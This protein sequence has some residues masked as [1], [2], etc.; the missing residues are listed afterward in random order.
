MLYP[1]PYFCCGCSV[2]V[3]LKAILF[4]HGLYCL[5][6]IVEAFVSLVLQGS[7]YMSTWSYETQLLNAMWAMVGLP[8][9]GMALYGLEK[10]LEASVRL[11]LYYLF[12]CFVL[13]TVQ[14]FYTLVF[15]NQCTDST[16]SDDIIYLFLGESSHA[17]GCGLSRLVGYL[18][19]S[20]I[21]TVEV[22]CLWLVWSF[23]AEV[24][25]GKTSVKV[26]DLLKGLPTS[27]F[28]KNPRQDG[29]YADIVGLAHT[30]LPGAYPFNYGALGSYDHDVARYLESD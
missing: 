28:K 5:F 22:Y 18:L 12:A 23:C 13:N 10:R 4:F 30:R 7:M 6:F 29:P 27:M 21:V 11:Y 24:A 17:F 25:D 3:G 8:L 2:A 19:V 15:M 1:L 9:I 16:S 14:A 20:A 26:Y